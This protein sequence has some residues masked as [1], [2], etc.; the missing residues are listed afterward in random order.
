MVRVEALREAVIGGPDS[1]RI[2]VWRNPQNVVRRHH[3]RTTCGWFDERCAST[4]GSG[5]AETELPRSAA[6]PAADRKC[7]CKACLQRREFKGV[8]A[9]LGHPA[10]TRGSGPGALAAGR[11]GVRRLVGRLKR[12][13]ARRSESSVASPERPRR[14]PAIASQLAEVENAQLTARSDRLI[15]PATG[16]RPSAASS[17]FLPAVVGALVLCGD[18]A[19]RVSAGGV[20]SRHANRK[21]GR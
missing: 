17:G 13:R 2:S 18:G 6:A 10:G 14:P 4:V 9:R 15:C 8:V 12:E 5:R 3:G 21:N 7:S 16:L 20:L 1:C 19:W 11:Y